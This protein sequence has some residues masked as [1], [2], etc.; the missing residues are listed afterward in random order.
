ME[1]LTHRPLEHSINDKQLIHLL[2]SIG[3]DRAGNQKRL[4]HVLF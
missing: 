2:P 4:Y 1:E 3:T